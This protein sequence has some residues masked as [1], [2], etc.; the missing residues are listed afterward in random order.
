MTT[1]VS[2]QTLRYNAKD[3]HGTI[4]CRD[5]FF[6]DLRKPA[7]PGQPNYL[8]T[9]NHTIS[10]YGPIIYMMSRG[11]KVD[12]DRLAQT[13][14]DIE[15]RLHSI[16]Q[17]LNEKCGEEL[18]PLS[19]DQVKAY[20]YIKK[21]IKPYTRLNDKKQQVIT[22]DD[23]ALQRLA[24]GT[25]ARPGLREASLIQ[26]YRKLSKLK[27]TYIDIRFDEDKRLRCSYNPRGTRFGR[28]SS[29]KTIFETGMNMQNLH[30][31]FLEF[32]VAD[33]GCCFLEFDKRQAE[34]IAVAYISGEENMISAVE[35]KLDVHVHTASNMFSVTP[36]LVKLDDKLIG[37]ESDPFIIEEIRSTNDNLAELAS[38]GRW[39]P[40]TM[41][42]RQCG[43]KSNHGL[44]YDERYKM[45]ALTNEITEKEAKVIYD[46]Y[47]RIYPGLQRWYEHIKDQLNTNGRVLTNLF[48]RPY[49]FLGRWDDDLWKS[50][51][52]FKP[53]S[54]VGE[55]VN[56]AM[57]SIYHANYDASLSEVE[58]LQQVHDSILFQ[59]PLESDNLGHAVC[60]I[61]KAMDIELT[62]GS[63]K[64]TIPTDLKVGFDKKNMVAVPL[65]AD[66]VEQESL[67]RK[68]LDGCKTSW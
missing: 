12:L 47:H 41:S 23:K 27:G 48:G 28:L 20:F 15:K 5:A 46:F 33:E 10:L 14:I 8:E 55:L 58:I 52:S 57:A 25:S 6:D 63:R 62:A 68:A 60:S 2:D 42:M 35:N 19:P 18:N 44:N 53:Q 66:P 59:H 50:A 22:V 67:I 51:Y 4:E 34:W 37:H 49:K 26:E 3:A 54:T 45:F 1:I 56:R 16:Q 38:S 7:Y 43:K 29:S 40:R 9:Y 64:F 61:H 39:L 21:K 17:E 32:M 13:R 24:R 65:V 36:E 30:P 31:A 11:I